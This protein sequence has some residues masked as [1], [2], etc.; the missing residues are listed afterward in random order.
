MGK[1]RLEFGTKS[2]K[3]YTHV[4][5]KQC[6]LLVHRSIKQIIISKT[7]KISKQLNLKQLKIRMIT[8]RNY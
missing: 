5:D 6:L 4:L 1:E 2:S 7:K 3:T 8:I